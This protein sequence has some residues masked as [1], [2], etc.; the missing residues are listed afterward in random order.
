MASVVLQPWM[1]WSATEPPIMPAGPTLPRWAPRAA[2]WVYV[3]AIEVIGAWL[4][5]RH[6]SRLREELGL[7]PVWR[8]FKWWW[9]PQRI[10]GLFPDWYG[11]PQPDWPR[12]TRLAGFPRP[13]AVPACECVGDDA[14]IVFTFGTG[15]RHASGLFAACA[16]A[17]K[18]L[19]RRGLFVT[20]HPGQ[21]PSPLPGAIRHV[22]HAPFAS[23]FPMCAAVVHHG[24]VGTT[25]AAL[26]AGTPQLIV[27]WAY[28]QF[29]NAVRVERLGVGASLWRRSRRSARHIAEALSRLLAPEVWER[30]REVAARC[31]ADGDALARAAEWVE[32]LAEER[33]PQ[34]A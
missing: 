27:P 26:A 6:L 34:L 21:L 19:G 23:L 30:C 3:N 10:I 7:R 33:K 25:A 11:P 24:G 12:Q 4:L 8:V 17:C 31:A 5:G 32:E 15:M 1:I 14:P 9:S 20:R 18:H 29:D 2:E 13:D 22:D 28:D 16:E